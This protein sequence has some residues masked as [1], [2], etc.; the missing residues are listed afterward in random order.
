MRA[1]LAIIFLCSFHFAGADE[2]DLSAKEAL[3][4]FHLSVLD[5]KSDLKDWLTV[6]KKAVADLKK[7][8]PN[9]EECR[10]TEDTEVCEKAILELVNYS[11]FELKDD[12]IFELEK[13]LKTKYKFEMK[14]GMKVFQ[15]STALRWMVKRDI[16]NGVPLPKEN[17]YRKGLR[18]FVAAIEEFHKE[19]SV[20]LIKAERSMPAFEKY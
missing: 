11:R 6:S 13:D 5:V 4:L 16:L 18:P 8:S 19:K 10:Q 2:K 15:L 9:A 1:F 3:Q 12:S 17:N 7:K 14:D 20:E